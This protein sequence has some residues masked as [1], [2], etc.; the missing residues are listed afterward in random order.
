MGIAADFVER[1][2][3]RRTTVRLNNYLVDEN[4]VRIARNDAD[5]LALSITN[6]GGAVIGVSLYNAVYGESTF[7]LGAGGGNL[8]IEV[9]E[10]GELVT[11]EVFARTLTGTTQVNVLEV[12]AV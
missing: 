12:V 10:D 1:H 9:A 3:G 7:L 4:G 8:I 6:A 2:F 5:R 11:H